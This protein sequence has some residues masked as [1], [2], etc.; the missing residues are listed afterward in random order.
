GDAEAIR[1]LVDALSAREIFVRAIQVDVASHSSQVDE[2][3]D[4]LMKSLRVL[5]PKTPKRRF[6]STALTTTARAPTFDAEYWWV[7]LREPVRLRARVEELVD[8]G[9]GFF[10]EL[11]PHPTLTTGIGETLSAK[12]PSAAVISSLRRQEPEREC[13]L[14]ALGNLH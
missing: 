5:K 3:R 13:L 2:L 11:S 6:A 7:N 12:S 4:E 14:E 9:Y 10:V 1:A 8:D